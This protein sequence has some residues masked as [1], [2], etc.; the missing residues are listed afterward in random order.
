MEGSS[1]PSV[2]Q[3]P[4]GSYPAPTAPAM[5][6]ASYQPNAVASVGGRAQPNGVTGSVPSFDATAATGQ[7]SQPSM[8]T[9]VA[10]PMSGQPYNTTGSLVDSSRIQQ[11][12][13]HLPSSAP[14]RRNPLEERREAALMCIGKCFS[15]PETELG[16]P[17]PVYGSCVRPA[18]FSPLMGDFVADPS[19]RSREFSSVS[20]TT[21]LPQPQPRVSSGPAPVAEGRSAPSTAPPQGGVRQMAPQLEQMQHQLDTL[22]RH[23]QSMLQAK[24][25][26]QI[27][28]PSTQQQQQY[29]TYASSPRYPP[30]T[31]RTGAHDHGWN[32]A[33]TLPQ[34]QSPYPATDR[35][36]KTSMLDIEENKRKMRALDFK[37]KRLQKE[38]HNTRL[39]R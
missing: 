30:V 33:A 39:D 21:Q 5:A 6:W 34:Q 8:T 22:T 31:S 15:A 13:H 2:S 7:Y 27:P 3:L 1:W 14:V 38:I 32:S 37:L 18:G 12:A 19:P 20:A 35:P 28:P 16:M 10:L 36:A 11:D 4:N 9:P 17:P 25:Q 29:P 26:P 23:M 24:T